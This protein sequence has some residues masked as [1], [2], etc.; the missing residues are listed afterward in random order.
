MPYAAS[1]HNLAR[2]GAGW[3]G[4]SAREVAVGGVTCTYEQAVTATEV[5]IAS[6]TS[7][8]APV[9]GAAGSPLAACDYHGAA[10][11]FLAAARE[12]PKTGRA[13]AAGRHVAKTAFLT[14][15]ARVLALAEAS[16][17]SRAM[18][19][20]GTDERYAVAM[21]REAVAIRE[22]AHA[23]ALR[24][25][26]RAAVESAVSECHVA[27]CSLAGACGTG[28]CRFSPPELSR[29]DMPAPEGRT[30]R[31]AGHQHPGS[32]FSASAVTSALLADRPYTVA[33]HVSDGDRATMADVVAA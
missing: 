10:A 14:A 6:R 33:V 22:R 28:R 20:F 31:P 2:P 5:L 4:L 24:A 3:P 23:A 11:P 30:Q 21:A 9:L 15:V 29:Y 1:P 12:L 18:S 8:I 7:A 32:G 27:G 26:V 13:G 17:L 19:A 16:E 25:Q